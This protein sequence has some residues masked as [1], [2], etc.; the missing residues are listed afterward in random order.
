VG[1]VDSVGTHALSI[2]AKS[3]CGDEV[4]YIRAIVHPKK[5][6]NFTL[7]QQFFSLFLP[8]RK[9]GIGVLKDVRAF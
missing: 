9:E 4:S 5:L 2:G 8:E 6:A 3:V 7:L 1:Y